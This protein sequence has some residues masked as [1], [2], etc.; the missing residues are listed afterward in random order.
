MTG[1]TL[2]VINWQDGLSEE[3]VAGTQTEA[4]GVYGREWRWE[5]ARLNQVMK[6]LTAHQA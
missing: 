3:A 6:I 1:W 4:T 2:T 5:R